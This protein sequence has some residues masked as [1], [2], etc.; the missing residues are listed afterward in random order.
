MLMNMPTLLPLLYC[1]PVSSSGRSVTNPQACATSQS[2]RHSRIASG[3]WAS[4]ANLMAPYCLQ[5]QRLSRLPSGSSTL[6]AGLMA[7][8]CWQTAVVNDPGQ[9]LC[10][11]ACHSYITCAILRTFPLHLRN[12]TLTLPKRL[13]FAGGNRLLLFSQSTP[14]LQ[15]AS[16]IFIPTLH[17]AAPAADNPLKSI[18]RQYFHGLSAQCERQR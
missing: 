4:R 5:L 16:P 3:L 1:V 2:H 15:L 10:R 7:P 11:P 14:T 6:R 9:P 13:P 17:F 8:S 18:K 12:K